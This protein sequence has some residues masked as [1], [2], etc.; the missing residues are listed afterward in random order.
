[1]IRTRHPFLFLSVVV[2]GL[3]AVWGAGYA[4]EV[5]VSAP[6]PTRTFEIKNN[7]LK[8]PSPILFETGTDK[9]LPESDKAL[10][11]VKAYLDQKDY[12]TI[13]RI[14]GHTDS[15]G[16][17]QANQ[18]LSEKRALSVARWLVGKG[19]DCTRLMPVGFGENKPVRS[20]ETAEGKAENRRMVFSNAALRGRPIGGMPVDGG[21]MVAGDPCAK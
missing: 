6:A 2:V 20:N 19:V 14:E 18:T 11:H 16:D 8:L 5:P 17:D 4:Q 3:S 21:G 10:E 7:E 15:D 1:M 12:I 13:L 9:L